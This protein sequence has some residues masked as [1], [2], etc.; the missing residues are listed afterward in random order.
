MKAKTEKKLT[1]VFV[2]VAI[3]IVYYLIAYPDMTVLR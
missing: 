2:I 1:V 3:G